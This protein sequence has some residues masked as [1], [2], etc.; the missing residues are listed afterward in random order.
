MTSLAPHE[1]EL[2]QQTNRPSKIPADSMS[3]DEREQSMQ[4]LQSLLLLVPTMMS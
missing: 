1:L 3:R 2:E 4:H